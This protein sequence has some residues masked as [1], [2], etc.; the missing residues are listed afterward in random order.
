MRLIDRFVALLGVSILVPA[1][2][3]AQER[4]LQPP[5]GVE[6]TG[7]PVLPADLPARLRRYTE[8]RSAVFTGWDPVARE[9]L[10]RTRF[11]NSAQV[12][13]VRAPGGARTQLSFFE[14]PVGLV[15]P[16]P[17]R[18]GPTVIGMDRNGDEFVQLFRFDPAT[19]DTVLLTDGR[20]SQNGGVA[21]SRTG[22]RIAFA[23]TMRNG[24]DRD[25]WVMD[26]RDPASRR[27]AYEAKGGGWSVGGWL[28]DGRG[29]LLGE[30]RS[31][32]QSRIWRLDLASGR[33]ELLLPRDT[34]GASANAV[35]FVAGIMPDGRTAWIVTDMG[36]EFRGLATLDLASGALT[37]VR[38]MPKGEVEGAALSRDGRR[39]AFTVN[40]AGQSQLYV[41][42]TA[43]RTP[44]RVTGVPAGVIGGL[45]WHPDGTV[46]GFTLGSARSPADAWS[47]DVPTNRATRWTESELGGVNAAELRD[48]EPV[49][50]TSF[51][52]R[53]ITGF[54]Y[55]PP[56]RFTGR[57][58]VIIDI[59]GG[60]ESQARPGFRGRTNYFLQELGAAIVTPNVRGSTGFGRTFVSLDNGLKRE[61]SVRDIGALLD[62][63]AR[64]PELDASRVM[65]MGGSYGGYMTLMAAT[66]YDARICCS[67][68]IVGIS[69][70]RTFLEN[71]SG[72]RRDLR[73]VEYGDERDPALRE[74][75]ER[76]APSNNASRITR[77]ML[78]IQGANDPRVPK[79]EA[80]Q[81]VA[82]V[83]KNGGEAWY[84]LDRD[85]GHGAAKKANADFQFQVMAEFARRHLAGGDTP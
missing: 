42:G 72:Y 70:L 52:G 37:P 77:P 24:T 25:I 83:R 5:P 41:L 45:G 12:H 44:R 78:V 76:T 71:T 85:E 66:T 27:L 58:P 53:E 62:W 61:D 4:P 51:D 74:F 10:I 64:Q 16:S 84:L 47:Y 40:D 23:S 17:V 75:M 50:W 31:V 55:R 49:R 54:L 20:P 7:A 18:G 81:M 36:G 9:M 67:I 82:A 2:A 35:H 60:P 19:G 59:H 39:L 1:M 79:T 11:A 46:L 80:D 57:R 6:L 68:D 33:A 48:P 69:N 8:A 29:L 28:P 13:R 21:W 26:P 65:V 63:I 38:G 3:R 73:R 14:Q 22:D 43:T 30:S 15:S 32:E 56:A 34:T